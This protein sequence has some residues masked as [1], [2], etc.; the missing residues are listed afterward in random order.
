MNTN[1]RSF[2]YKNILQGNSIII[3]LLLMAFAS[4]FLHGCGTSYSN[5]QNKGT[6]PYCLSDTIL[7]SVTIDTVKYKPV[8][9]ELLLSAEI[10]TDEEKQVKIYPLAS[11]RVRRLNVQLGDYVTAGQL[12]AVLASPDL[13]EIKNE[14]VVATR[15]LAIAKKNMNVSEEFYKSG[16]VSE[17][18]YITNKEEY[19]KA[20]SLVNK[21]DEI[22]KIYGGNAS[23]PSGYFIK[24]P[25]SGFIVDKNINE[26]MELRPDDGNN[27]VTIAD[28]KD[29]WVMANVY[30]T[31]ID[32]II[33]GDDV[34]VSPLSYSKRVYK[35]KI[36]KI[37][38]VI[39]PETKVL[40]VRVILKNPDYQ[41][42]PGMFA[43][44]IIHYTDQQKML[45]IPTASVIFDENKNWVLRYY[46]NCNFEIVPVN[47]YKNLNGYS[48]LSGGNLRA[49]DR[50]IT[51]TGLYIYTELRTRQ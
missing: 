34:D 28:L 9:D 22:L 32:K 48:Y 20:L 17:K 7:R 14:D 19:E 51:K 35:G 11:G 10:K 27:I 33:L 38:N 1:E 6:R 31:D 8:L 15:D 24:S 42:K 40:N 2:G 16:L 29:V 4:V 41:L 50:I 26:G 49:D 37:F 23:D 36:D 25:I 13:A 3:R 30:E 18:D 12:L 47:V 46:N 39:N 43:R 5:S 45:T 21:N 44:V